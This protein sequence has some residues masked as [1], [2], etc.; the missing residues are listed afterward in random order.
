MKRD[1]AGLLFSPSDQHISYTFTFLKDKEKQ[2]IF[3]LKIKDLQKKLK[4]QRGN[5]WLLCINHKTINLQSPR[6]AQGMEN[7]HSMIISFSGGV[8]GYGDNREATVPPD[9]IVTDLSVLSHIIHP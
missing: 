4:S 9:W 5:L 8:T 3:F 1:G 2:F 7:S 6:K